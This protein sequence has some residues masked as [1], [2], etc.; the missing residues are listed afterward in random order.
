MGNK[1]DDVRDRC[2]RSMSDLCGVYRGGHPET[3][4]RVL[5]GERLSQHKTVRFLATVERPGLGSGE[6]INWIA[7]LR[8]NHN[9]T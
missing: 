3:L 4:S 9:V 6:R 1:M 5:E 2:G 7:K 8:R